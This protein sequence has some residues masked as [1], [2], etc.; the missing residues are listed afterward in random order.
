MKFHL[1]RIVLLLFVSSIL[2][3]GKE[4]TLPDADQLM[5]GMIFCVTHSKSPNMVI[6]RLIHDGN[7]QGQVDNSTT[8]QAYWLL[9]NKG[10]KVE[11]LTRIE[12]KM[13]FGFEIEH[14]FPNKIQ[15][16]LNAI[17]NRTIEIVTNSNT[18]KGW[19]GV[20]RIN[21]IPACLNEVFIDFKH[22]LFGP[23]VISIDFIGESLAGKQSI[24]ER[25][26]VRPPPMSK[27]QSID[28]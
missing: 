19:M 10:N 23:K 13:A 21:D 18:K 8:V 5:E 26:W 1:L 22:S 28:Q 9:T 16:R 4:E 24:T 14:S 11:R 27:E 3:C 6:Y 12:R 2:L 7:T 15:I 25:I 20:M 17:K